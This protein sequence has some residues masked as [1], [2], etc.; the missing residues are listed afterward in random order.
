M[1]DYKVIKTGSR[2]NAIVINGEIMIDCGVS[3]KALR[4]V[5]KDLRL[6]LLTHRHG[7]HCKP[8]T[9]H[10]L[11][12]ERPSLRWGMGNWMLGSALSAGIGVSN[13]DIYSGGSEYKYTSYTVGAFGLV[14]DARNC[15]YRID[16]GGERLF[17]ATD[18]ANL[19]GVV[20]KDYDL[21]LIEANYD[22]DDAVSR[23]ADK[24]TRG[25]YAYE[26]RAMRNHL[27]RQQALDWLYANMGAK[28][29]YAFL[30]E[31]ED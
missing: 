7:D 16:I 23:I 17:Y 18:T 24:V 15:G 8:S 31:H 25:E 2:G 19:E 5:Y 3:Y 10:T 4:E 11:A 1:I 26:Y 12:R 30:H 28:S 27:S 29:E 22:E 20:A 9:V 14:H 13:I 6:V 21:Y